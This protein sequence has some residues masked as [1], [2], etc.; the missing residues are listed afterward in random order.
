MFRS[1]ALMTSRVPHFK[2]LVDYCEATTPQMG[3]IAARACSAAFPARLGLLPEADH[4]RAG[5]DHS[6]VNG[7]GA[8]VQPRST[9][10][11]KTPP[12]TFKLQWLP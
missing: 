10:D 12:K 8:R 3:E 5:V 1:S 4:G 11:L 2:T 9:K 7:I 6:Q